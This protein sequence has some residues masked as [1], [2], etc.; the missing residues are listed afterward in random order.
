MLPRSLAKGGKER[1]AQCQPLRGICL[2]DSRS[3]VPL[4]HGGFRPG[5]ETPRASPSVAPCRCALPK[6]YQVPCTCLARSPAAIG[7][8]R[9]LPARAAVRANLI[10]QAGSLTG[11]ASAGGRF[12]RAHRLARPEVSLKTLPS[13]SR[14]LNS[15][16]GGQDS[17]LAGPLWGCGFP[18]PLAPT[19]GWAAR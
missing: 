11:S 15:S 17:R 13:S 3:E 14:G 2:T 18:K 6:R 5:I 4:L 8:H 10:A 16:Q 9:Q 19:W 7:P 12:R 1:E